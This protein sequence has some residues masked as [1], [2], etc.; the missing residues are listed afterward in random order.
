M[1]EIPKC[2]VR[3]LREHLTTGRTSYGSR[4]EEEKLPQLS[5]DSELS[6]YELSGFFMLCFSPTGMSSMKGSYDACTSGASHVFLQSQRKRFSNKKSNGSD[7]SRLSLP[8]NNE[9]SFFH[10]RRCRC[11][12][13]NKIRIE[14]TIFKL[15]FHNNN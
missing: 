9:S 13:S 8:L 15:Y 14:Q 1:K 3:R 10:S 6:S 5:V 2:R 4:G 7:I 11:D 12:E